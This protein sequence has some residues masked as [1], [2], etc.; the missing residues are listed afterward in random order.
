VVADYDDK[1]RRLVA[2]APFAART[3]QFY[4]L[5]AKP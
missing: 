5:G 4:L 2:F 1:N 3:D